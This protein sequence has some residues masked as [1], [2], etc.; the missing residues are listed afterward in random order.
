MK[1]ISQLV[2]HVADLIEAEGRT[3][4]SIVRDQGR[5]VH[6]AT[7]SAA[8]AVMFLVMTVPF[9]LAGFGLLAAG[10]LWGLEP[11]VGRALAAAATGAALLMIG[12]GCFAMFRAC[13]RRPGP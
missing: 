4:L 7:M 2:V 11:V 9:V 8:V 13:S 12:A 5:R 3:L 6:E 1:A 10:L